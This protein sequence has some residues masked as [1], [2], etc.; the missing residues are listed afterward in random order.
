MRI[1]F[2]TA[3]EGWGGSEI[4]L[5]TLML[6]LRQLGH[7]PVLIGID[8]SR[9]FKELRREGVECVAWKT[10]VE[11]RNHGSHS[12][13]ARLQ[14]KGLVAGM[15][16]VFLG[17]LP[18][19]LKLLAGN[20][21]EVRLLRKLFVDSKMDVV[22]VNVHGY[23]VAGAAAK[24]AGIKVVGFYHTSPIAESNV[25]R[26]WLVSA[27]GSYYDRLC[28]PSKFAAN[29]WRQVLKVEPA[30][31]IVVPHGI[32]LS[33]FLS[34]VPPSRGPSDLFRLVSVGRLHPMKGYACLLNVIAEMNDK[35]VT[36]EVLGDGEEKDAL[37]RQVDALGLRGQVAL[38][39]HVE[40]PEAVIQNSHAFILLSNSHESFGLAVVEAM[41]AGLP[42][43]TTDFGPFTE[44]NKA[45]DTGLVAPVGN[46]AAAVKA[47]R[48]LADSPELC[49][50]MG[51]IGRERAL[52]QYSEKRM[53]AEMVKLY[54]D[55]LE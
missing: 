34:F 8:G 14:S 54:T 45:G 40:H 47:I 35:R 18:G 1:G 44:I 27:T 31:C 25:V 28:F 55:L 16:I 21:R 32:D 6:S 5:K 33:R 15:K 19:W 26:R 9:L 30:L 36:L 3:I 39:G 22:Q 50:K 13:D 12:A 51:N 20:V 38:R 41:A 43:I 17:L 11:N 49:L 23:E 53:I 48:L 52:K 2:F 4:Y 7:D 10:I 29:A 46:V 42:I 37:T 24:L